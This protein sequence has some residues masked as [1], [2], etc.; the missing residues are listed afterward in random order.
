LTLSGIASGIFQNTAAV[1]QHSFSVW[2]RVVSGD[3]N[4]NF[5][6]YDGADNHLQSAVA[7]GEW[8]RF[9]W[10]FSGNGSGNSNVALMHDF[11]QSGT[12]VF[13]VWGAQLNGGDSAQDYLPTTNTPIVINNPDP[14]ELIVSSTLTISIHGSGDLDMLSFGTAERGVVADLTTRE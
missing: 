14:A 11:T 13:E 6:Y 8:Q 2:M 3:G 5:N 7:T 10:T 12:G 9:T 1:G 4:F